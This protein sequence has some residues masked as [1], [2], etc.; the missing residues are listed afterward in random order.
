[1]ISGIVQQESFTVMFG[2]GLPVVVSRTWHV[3]G[4]LACVVIVAFG[5][6]CLGSC[7]DMLCR[8]SMAGL[9]GILGAI[10]R[11]QQRRRGGVLTK[12]DRYFA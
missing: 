10:S 2:A 1:M 5:R 12:V 9:R 4:S 6:L 11:R 7:E 8:R 3:I